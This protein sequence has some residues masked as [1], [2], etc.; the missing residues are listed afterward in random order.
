MTIKR[1]LFTG[2]MPAIAG[3][4]SGTMYLDGD[5]DGSGSNRSTSALSTFRD[6]T[7]FVIF[8]TILPSDDTT[9]ISYLFESE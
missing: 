4:R 5:F 6:S 2:N 7:S 3:T 9:E 8:R 1:P